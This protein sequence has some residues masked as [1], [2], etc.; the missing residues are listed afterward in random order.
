[1]HEK[2]ILPLKSEKPLFY[3]KDKLQELK[4]ELEEFLSDKDNSYMNKVAFAERFMG[5]QEIQSNNSIEGYNDDVK[6]IISVTSRQRNNDKSDSIITNLYNGYKMI[7]ECPEINKENLKKLYTILS[8]DLISEEDKILMGEYYR[9]APVYI[10]Y[11]RILT[12]APD[13]GVDYRFI[14]ECMDSLFDYLNDGSSTLSATD[15]FIK[16]QIAHYY[17]VYVHPYFDVN[18]RTSRTVG[19]WHLLNNKA[20][21]YIIFNRAI[22]LTLKKYYKIIREVRA[23]NNAT[24]FLNYMLGNVKVELEKERVISSI[25][26]SI[27]GELTASDYQT[28]LYILSLNGLK[29]CKDFASFYNRI[30]GKTSVTTVRDEMLMPLIDKDILKVVRET[31]SGLND[32]TNNF[33]FQLN[34]NLIDDDPAKIKKLKI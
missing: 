20:Y 30:N 2:I 16:S 14:D 23:F 28:L 3:N 10:Y 4:E 12:T 6:R 32:G 31:N 5:C 26:E 25:N 7:L 11:S 1:M 24:F 17:F 34:R 22:P 27:H 18:G 33:V 8:N 29:S 13:E 19:M 9:N 15:Q 21:P